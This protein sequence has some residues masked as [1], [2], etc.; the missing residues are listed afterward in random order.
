MPWFKVDDGFHGH[1]KVMDLSLA[2]VG[3]WTLAGS[4]CAKYLTDGFVPDKTV[5]RLGGTVE[6]A[7]ELH[8]A[9]LW[10]GCA[11]GWQF[12]DWA[13]YQPTKEEV[14]AE[15]AAARERMKKVR[16]SKKGVRSGEQTP[17][18]ER[19]AEE[20]RLA[21]SQSHPIP[22]PSPKGEESTRKRAHSIPNDF[23]ISDR[24]RQWAAENVPLVNI[25]AKL[26]EFIDYWKGVGKPMKDWESVWH[27]GMRKQQG[28]ALRDSQ[29]RATRGQ[30]NLAYVASLMTDQKGIDS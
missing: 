4:W 7:A 9:D 17:N 19:S 23:S 30:E 21:P 6:A 10:E 26:P 27:N 22:T 5:L 2:A 20:V 14:E 1:P 13:D 29:P 12:K 25:D 11:G 15:R 28:F 18:D 8:S 24:M 3:L 16:A